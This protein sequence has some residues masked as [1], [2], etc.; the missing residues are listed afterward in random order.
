MNAGLAADDRKAGIYSTAL[1]RE[2][3]KD[4]RMAS[5][6]GKAIDSAGQIGGDALK[7]SREPEEPKK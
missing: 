1:N 6:Y 3:A 5:F 2:T 7:A 4:D